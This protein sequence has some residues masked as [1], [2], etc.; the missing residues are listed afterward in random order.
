MMKKSLIF[1]I[2]ALFGDLTGF[3][4]AYLSGLKRHTPPVSDI[5]TL[6]VVEST[7]N[8]LFRT[9]ACH[10]ER[11]GAKYPRGITKY[12]KGVMKNPSHV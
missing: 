3:R 12:P 1:V 2:L 8:I 7:S 4:A 10:S 9:Y 5:V 6:S 11:S